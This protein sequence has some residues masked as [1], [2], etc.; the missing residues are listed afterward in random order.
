MSTQ[1]EVPFEPLRCNGSNYP[2]WSAHVLNVLR[3]MGPSFERVV[4][5]SVLPNDVDDL[6]KLSTKKRNACRATVVLLT[7]CL[8]VWT[9]NFQIPYKRRSY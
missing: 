6:S 1:C 3:T 2:S 9:K 7:F 4:K 8:S 5:A